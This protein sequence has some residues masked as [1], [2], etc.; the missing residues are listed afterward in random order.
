MPKNMNM[1]KRKV[2]LYFMKKVLMVARFAISLT[3]SLDLTVQKN[4]NFY[5]ILQELLFQEP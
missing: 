2:L 5:L 1:V 4:I 3:F